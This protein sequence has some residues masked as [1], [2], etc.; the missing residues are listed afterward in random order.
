MQYTDEHPDI[1]GTKRLIDQLK[2]RKREEASKK[3]RTAG[4]NFSPMVQQMNVALSVEEARLAALQTR[5][6]EYS[7]RVAAL[8]AMSTAAPEVEAELSQLN[9]DY[10]INKENYA[11]LVERRESARLSGDLS[12]A[13]DMMTIRVI[14]PPSA[15]V[16]PVGPNRARLCS[17]VFAGAL[18]AGLGS[19]LLLSQI[20]PTFISQR[21]L[22]ETTGIPILGSI[23][24]NWTD[25]Q[26]LKRRRRLYAFGLAVSLFFGGYGGVMA[27][28]LWMQR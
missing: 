2:A 15:P 23:S 6:R 1:A 3:V 11:K 22:R 21:A 8:R 10:A 27:S 28:V 25:T 19:A 16:M 7:S 18:L 24:M 14:D 13:S 17:I 9:R 20:R 5:V 12:S 4:A 26:R